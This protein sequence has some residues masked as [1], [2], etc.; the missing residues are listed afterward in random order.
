MERPERGK[1]KRLAPGQD[2]GRGEWGGW[3]RSKGKGWRQDEEKQ[4]G[5]LCCK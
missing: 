5:M 1:E 2:N 3:Q 4:T